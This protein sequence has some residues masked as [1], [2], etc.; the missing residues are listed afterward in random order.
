MKKRRPKQ[1]LVHGMAQTIFDRISPG[2][3]KAIE[4]NY[5][6]LYAEAI[7]TC[8]RHK[9]PD[10]E[11]ENVLHGWCLPKFVN[12]LDAHDPK[13]GKLSTIFCHSC[14]RDVKNLRRWLERSY[15]TPVTALSVEAM[16]N[17]GAPP[18][19]WHPVVTDDQPLYSDKELR[20]QV[21]GLSSRERCMLHEYYW[22]GMTLQG[23]ADRHNITRE[24]VRQIIAKARKLIRRRLERGQG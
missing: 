4:E 3:R 24:R 12:C 10:N 5:G 11:V 23:V 1:P 14:R 21:K 9:L 17:D 13:R 20:A 8:N 15:M 18:D 19:W 7:W 2:Q 6:L 22:Q 16:T